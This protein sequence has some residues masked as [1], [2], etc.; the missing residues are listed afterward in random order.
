MQNIYPF[1]INRLRIEDANFTYV[2]AD[3]KR[4][5]A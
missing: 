1:E 4:L 5:L 3:P 2:D